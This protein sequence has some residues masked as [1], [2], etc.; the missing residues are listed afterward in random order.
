MIARIWHGFATPENAD[1]YEKLTQNETFVS[2]RNRNIP[3]FQEIQLLRRN[4]AYE[5]EFIT[6]MWFDSV[7][8]IRAYAGNDF[9]KAV[10]PPKA[11]AF[12]FRFDEITQLYE[13]LARV[14]GK[15]PELA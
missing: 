6:I 2:I 4:H 8:S 14:A 12:L 15:S 13:V 1:E 3:G 9:E 11:Q 10:V 7:D 5:V